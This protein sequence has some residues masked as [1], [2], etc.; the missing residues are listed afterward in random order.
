MLGGGCAGGGRLLRCLVLLA[1]A[2]QL[3]ACAGGAEYRARLA[4]LEA[5]TPTCD[6]EADCNAKWRAARVWVARNI[7]LPIRVASS[8]VIETYHG[9]PSQDPRLYARVMRE[10]LGGS[11]YRIAIVADCAYDYGCIPNRWNSTLGFD[12]SVAAAAPRE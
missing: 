8:D 12:R 1:A 6:G 9:Y 3:C 4:R 2:V 5:A 10:P 7:N 11:R